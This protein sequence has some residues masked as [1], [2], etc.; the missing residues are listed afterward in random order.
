MI[1]DFNWTLSCIL[2]FLEL[3]QW[4]KSRPSESSQG[5]IIGV[6]GR[7]PGKKPRQQSYLEEQPHMAEMQEAFILQGCEKCPPCRDSRRTHCRNSHTPG[8][9]EPQTLL[10]QKQDTE[11]TYVHLGTFRN[12]SLT[13]AQAAITADNVE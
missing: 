9:K 2:V 5:A 8:M 7:N 10:D 4:V 12:C 3:L 13:K 1:H 6:S 11:R